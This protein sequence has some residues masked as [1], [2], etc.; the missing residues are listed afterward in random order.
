MGNNKQGGNR[1]QGHYEFIEHTADIAIKAYGDSLEQAFA[2][3]ASAMFDIMTDGAAVVS[4]ESI[5]FDTESVDREGLLVGFLSDLIV[6][7]EVQGYV[8][9]EF[10]ITFFGE[11]RL[12]ARCRGEMFDESRHASGLHV[13]GVSYHMLEMF[14][15]AGEKPSF[16]QVLFDV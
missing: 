8:F 12:R 1:S 7:H 16:V 15:G 2:V 11:N 9:G 3:A 13:K 14:D 6:L 5:D 4:E 10:E